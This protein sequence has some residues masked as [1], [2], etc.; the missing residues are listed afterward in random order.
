[1]RWAALTTKWCC[2]TTMARIRCRRWTSCR[3]REGWCWRLRRGCRSDGPRPTP[4][5]TPA[6]PSPP[7][8]R[9]PHRHSRE[10]LTVIPANPSP[11]FPRIPHRHSR[12]SLTVIPANPS[13]SFPRIPHR[14]SREGGN[15]ATVHSMPNLPRDRLHF[16]RQVTEN[17]VFE[18]NLDAGIIDVDPDQIALGVVIENHA[19]R[20]LPALGAGFLG[21][22]Y[23]ERIGIRMVVEFHGLNLVEVGRCERLPCLP[24]CHPQFISYAGRCSR[25]LHKQKT[26]PKRNALLRTDCFCDVLENPE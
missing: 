6:N 16:R 21:K 26:T 7:F 18:L 19:F 13:P 25:T 22:V 4:T 15:P 5:V 2:S 23:V 11:S 17:E 12:E 9:I 20:C 3:W 8:L 1:M 14:H 24:G 10:S